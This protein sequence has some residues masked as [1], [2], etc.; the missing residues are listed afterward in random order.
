MDT[1]YINGNIYLSDRG[2]PFQAASLAVK[3]G[4]ILGIGPQEGLAKLTGPDT[5]IVDLNGNYV[6]PSFFDAHCHPSMATDALYA[7]KLTGA[8]SPDDYLRIVKSYAAEHPKAEAITG[9]GWL[10]AAFAP[11]EPSKHALDAIRADIPICLASEDG[12]SLWVNSEMLARAGITKES[13]DPD[14][15]LVSR[16]AE[17]N[18]AGLIVDGPA[19]Y[20]VKDALPAY[21]LEQCKEAILWFQENKALPYGI[22]GFFDALVKPHSN[23]L[24]AYLAL[25]A[26]NRLALRVRAAFYADPQRGAE[27]IRACAQERNRLAQSDVFQMN[28]IK[29]FIDG[30]VEGKTAVLR[31]AYE[32]EPGGAAYNAAPLWDKNVLNN[33]CAEAERLGFRLHFHAIGD[34]AVRMALD[35][36]AYAREQNGATG[37]KHAIAHVQLVAPEDIRRFAEYG[38][39][40]SLNPYWMFKD[41]YYYNIQLPYLGRERAEAEYPVQSF[42]DAGAVANAGSDYPVTDPPNP[43]EGIQVGVTRKVPQ[44][45][46][47]ALSYGSIQDTQDAKYYE[48]LWPQERASVK[49][50]L[51]AFTYNGAWTYA[52]GGVT[53]SIA[54][55][56]SA[57]FAVLTENI[58]TCDPESLR[59]VKVQMT[60]FKGKTVFSA[61]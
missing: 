36:V 25:A 9:I 5:E 34:G 40:A 53:G 58:F 35:A 57:D 2:D 61:G 8:S 56:K 55:G 50:M 12:H 38:V 44:S 32:A 19:F 20:A 1:I 7:A 11:E 24:A 10:N 14:T 48:P 59:D 37:I 42:L 54:A 29:I 31:E 43:L 41:D 15:G 6:V 52:L 27:Q 46:G 4:L 30:V 60:V 26:E 3:D 18:P 49:D 21:T 13:P 23:E 17:G 39:I 28:D 47:L 45:A 33:V 16:D 22:T 51:K